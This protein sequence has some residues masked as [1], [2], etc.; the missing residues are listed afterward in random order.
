[1]RRPR[2]RRPTQPDRTGGPVGRRRVRARRRGDGARETPDPRPVGPCRGERARPCRAKAGAARYWPGRRHE[3]RSRRAT[4]GGANGCESRS[5]GGA[6]GWRGGMQAGALF[7]AR[8]ARIR[9]KSRHQHAIGSVHEMN[10]GIDPR[11]TY[12]AGFARTHH[13]G[14]PDPAPHP[15]TTRRARPGQ[16]EPASPIYSMPWSPCPRVPCFST[17]GADQRA[18]QGQH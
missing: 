1:M 2:P 15:H 3:R 7:R 5:A 10:P 11:R 13:L 14:G 8:R 4:C 9:C 12:R 18:T 16:R 6:G 17:A